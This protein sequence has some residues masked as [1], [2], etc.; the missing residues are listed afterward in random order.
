MAMDLALVCTL[1]IAIVL[2]VFGILIFFKLARVTFKWLITIILNSVMG[3]V[4]FFLLHF[5]GINIPIWPQVL[6][7]ALFGL[8]A[9]ATMLILKFFGVA[10]F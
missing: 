1:G 10:V 9:L 3:V 7:V 2:M 5:I 8:P 4:L 6:P